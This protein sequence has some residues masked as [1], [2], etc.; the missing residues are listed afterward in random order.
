MSKMKVLIEGKVTD[1]DPETEPAPAVE[2]TDT[3]FKTDNKLIPL[4]QAHETAFKNLQRVFEGA[5]A[6]VKVSEPKRDVSQNQ[7]LRYELNWQKLR[8]A[9]EPYAP[10]AQA[11]GIRV[12]VPKYYPPASTHDTLVE[13]QPEPVSPKASCYEETR[14]LKSGRGAPNTAVPE[15]KK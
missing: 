7:R 4:A 10:L 11:R 15:V 12:L 13:Y 3:T 2:T 1:W 5:L 6:A 14:G 9:A 8:A